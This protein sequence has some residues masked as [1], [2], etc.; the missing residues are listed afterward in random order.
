M[1]CPNPVQVKDEAWLRFDL[2]VASGSHFGASR[3]HLIQLIN[4]EIANEHDE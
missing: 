4:R 2:E 3:P 1:A